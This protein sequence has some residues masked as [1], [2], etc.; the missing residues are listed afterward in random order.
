M[1]TILGK[2]DD[3]DIVHDTLAPANTVYVFDTE[4]VAGNT[5][6]LRD[7]TENTPEELRRLIETRRRMRGVQ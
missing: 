1:R 5:V 6:T 3:H 2:F 7:F 4:I